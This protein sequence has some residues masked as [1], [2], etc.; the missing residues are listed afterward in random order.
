MLHV[1]LAQWSDRING[2]GCQGEGSTARAGI[3][4]EPWSATFGAKI[5]A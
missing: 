3:W 5:A 4:T 2:A 1:A